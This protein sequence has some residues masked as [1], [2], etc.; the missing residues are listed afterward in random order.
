MKVQF[1]K[2]YQG[3][4]LS[5]TDAK[6]LFDELF[7]GSMTDIELASLLT[8]LKMKGETPDEIGGEPAPW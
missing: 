8:A 7:R 4:N 6:D 1:E 3:Q 5:R 2:L